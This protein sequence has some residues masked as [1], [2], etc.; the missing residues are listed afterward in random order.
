MVSYCINLDRRADKWAYART[1]FERMGIRVKRFS[2]F[3]TRPGWVG[4]RDSHIAIMELCR[5][6][7]MLTIY[8][9]DVQFLATQQDIALAFMEL[10]AD[11]DMLSLGCSPQEPFERYSEHLFKMG[12]AWTT[13]AIIWR[14]R[15]GGAVEYILANKDR[16]KKIDVFFAEEIYPQF[17]C[18]VA[19]PL[20]VTQT[21]FQSDTCK[22]SDV[23][24]I[25]TQY[26]KF[27]I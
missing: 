21:Q 9:D 15:K 11:W 5:G 13:H 1:E 24:T 20:A 8:E 25:I 4:C 19:Y 27:C 7:N 26:N 2:A 22:R 18:F 16:I 10:P 14:N 3:D 23:S 6:E 17:N 12:K